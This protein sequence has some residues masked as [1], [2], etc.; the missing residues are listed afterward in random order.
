MCELS[1][2]LLVLLFLSQEWQAVTYPGKRTIRVRV[3]VFQGVYKDHAGGQTGDSPAGPVVSSGRPSPWQRGFPLRNHVPLPRRE[4][5]PAETTRRNGT[6]V[7]C[8]SNGQDSVPEGVVAFGENA[9]R[10]LYG[11]KTRKLRTRFGL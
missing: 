11:C 4:G 7:C 5:P 9:K 1:G 6:W 2:Q 8:D 3:L 10:V